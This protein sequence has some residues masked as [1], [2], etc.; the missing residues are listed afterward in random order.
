M[1]K[2]CEDLYKCRIS[3]NQWGCVENTPMN[4]EYPSLI[5]YTYRQKQ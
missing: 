3:V 1:C 2:F 4:V 5:Q